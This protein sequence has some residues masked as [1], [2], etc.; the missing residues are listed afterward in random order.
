[1]G[2]CPA[3]RGRAIKRK[4]SL[5]IYRAQTTGKLAELNDKPKRKKFKP[6]ESRLSKLMRRAEERLQREE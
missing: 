3:L 6:T 4:I 2:D 1:M 5:P